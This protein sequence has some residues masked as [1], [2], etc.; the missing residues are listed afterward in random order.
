MII[1]I[2]KL[3]IT[4]KMKKEKLKLKITPK[5]KKYSRR[6]ILKITPKIHK[7]KFIGKT[8]TEKSV[9]LKQ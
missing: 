3:K 2:V 6:K 7:N 1:H 9:L 4:P 5:T 8:K